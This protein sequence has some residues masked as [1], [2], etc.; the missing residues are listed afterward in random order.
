MA[1]Q[2]TSQ[3][4]G[5]NHRRVPVQCPHGGFVHSSCMLER[6][7]RLARGHIDLKSS[8]ACSSEW[9]G[10]R[11]PPYPTELASSSGLPTNESGQRWAALRSTIQSADLLQRDV[12]GPGPASYLTAGVYSSFELMVCAHGRNPTSSFLLCSLFSDVLGLPQEG[13]LDSPLSREWEVAVDLYRTLFA[14]FGIR[15][16]DILLRLPNRRLYIGTQVQEY[17]AGL[18]VEWGEHLTR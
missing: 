13:Y 10:G 12:P 3:G 8:A 6:V 15:S 1:C 18:D 7:D 11:R 5:D 4:K 9:A 2:P 17:L 14:A 16:Q